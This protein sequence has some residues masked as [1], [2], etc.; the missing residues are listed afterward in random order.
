[1]AQLKM[2]SNKTSG[3]I[4]CCDEK[5]TC[6]SL[7]TMFYCMRNASFE[8]EFCTSIEDVLY[9]IS[10]YEQLIESHKEMNG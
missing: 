9:R 1:M 4:F 8:P 10:D 7:Y 3:H 2:T 6:S 5:K